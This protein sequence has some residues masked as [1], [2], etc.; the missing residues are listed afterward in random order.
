MKEF[1]NIVDLVSHLTG[2]GKATKSSWAAGA[3]IFLDVSKNIYIVKGPNKQAESFSLDTSNVEYFDY[4]EP[5]FVEL[6]S[7]CS[8]SGEV[9]QAVAGSY[10]D[11]TYQNSPNWKE[12][13]NSNSKYLKFK[14]KD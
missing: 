8:E 12:I 13:I 3:Y 4:V 6:K 11:K 9:V 7:Y 2:G 14:L 10:C 1:N 5:K